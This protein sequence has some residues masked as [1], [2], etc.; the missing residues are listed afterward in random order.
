MSA[1]PAD[2]GDHILGFCPPSTVQANHDPRFVV[3]DGDAA[4]CYQ[5]AATNSFGK[6]REDFTWELDHYMITIGLI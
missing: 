1:D 3:R 6:I 2:W 4:N 5:R